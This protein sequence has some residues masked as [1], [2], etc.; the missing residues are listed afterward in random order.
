[1]AK[2][3]GHTLLLYNLVA[4]VKMY[5]NLELQKQDLSLQMILVYCLPVK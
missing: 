5:L 4:G 1:M 3:L 2:H